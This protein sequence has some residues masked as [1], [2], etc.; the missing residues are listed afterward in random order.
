MNEKE[1]GMELVDFLKESL[2]NQF[3]KDIGKRNSLMLRCNFL[4]VDE[5]GRYLESFNSLSTARTYAKKEAS[6]HTRNTYIIDT[7]T[8]DVIFTY[9]WRRE[10]CG[11]EYDLRTE[12]YLTYYENKRFNKLKEIMF[13]W[14]NKGYIEEFL[15]MEDISGKSKRELEQL[16]DKAHEQMPEDVLQEF[17]DRFKITDGK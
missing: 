7:V 10:D 4:V 1:R 6:N 17:Y 5:E 13:N 16:L 8:L 12:K 11:H 15:G 14:M 9:S 2:F 3:L